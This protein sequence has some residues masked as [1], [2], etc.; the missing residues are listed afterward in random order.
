MKAIVFDNS[1]VG[2]QRFQDPTDARH[3]G[4]VHVAA[5][6]HTRADGCPGIDH[7]PRVDVGAD[8][9]V[10]G[11]QHHVRRDIGAAAR[12]RGRHHAHAGLSEGGVVE[13]RKLG[14]D[15]VVKAK[16]H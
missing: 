12:D 11:H 14:R 2:L 7:R 1:G 16:R 10:A 3:P 6:L 8:V 9:D 13:V 5:D 4:Q 15:L